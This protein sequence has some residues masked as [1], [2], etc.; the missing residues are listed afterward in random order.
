MKKHVIKTQIAAIALCLLG[1]CL[2][3]CSDRDYTREDADKMAK[4][5]S[6]KYEFV[7]EQ[8]LGEKETVWT[9]HDKKFDWDFI[10]H[11]EPYRASFDGTSWDARRLYSNYDELIAEHILSMD[12]IKQAGFEPCTSGRAYLSASAESRDKLQEQIKCLQQA[13]GE[14]NERTKKS[15]YKLYAEFT[16]GKTT[17][18]CY[19]SIRALKHIEDDILKRAYIFYDETALTWYSSAEIKKLIKDNSEDEVIF[20]Y[21][22]GH[23][24]RTE[25]IVFSGN[26]WVSKKSFRHYLETH[27]YEVTGNDDE[28]TFTNEKGEMQTVDYH[29]GGNGDSLGFYD[30]Q[31]L[32]GIKNVSVIS[33]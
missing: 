22:D 7:S 2:T 17:E 14:M 24:E 27:G 3:G 25:M 30:L 13:V 9:Y 31:S 6:K 28:Y 20:A 18:D 29:T 19:L 8:V 12:E 33:N 4:A 26:T 1:L 32:M 11:E 23:A 21:D 15:E 16:L 5:Y 10:I